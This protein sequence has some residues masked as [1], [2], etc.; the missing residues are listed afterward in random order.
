MI[1]QF[2]ANGLCSGALY[3]IVALGFGLIY[4]STGIFH[5]AH[6]AVY[7]AG[8][9][10]LYLFLIILKFN[11]YISLLFSLLGASILGNLIETLVYNPMRKRKVSPSGFM[12]GSFGVYLFVVNLIALL[13]G[14]ETKVLNPGIEK[15]FSFGS[16]ILTRIQIISF[17]TFIVVSLLFLLFKRTKTGNLIIAFSNNPKLIETIGYNP[18][19]IR[20]IIFTIGSILAAISSSLSALDVGIDPN[21]GMSA[22]F[23][24]AVAVIIGGVNVFE[25]AILGGILIGILQ[26]LVVWQTSAK[27]MDAFTFLILI[28]FLLFRPKGILSKK[29]RIEESV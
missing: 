6:G 19:K 17:I 22:L 27:W 14:N 15:T 24:S 3:S 23:V 21:I 18:Y 28:I 7:V 13:F 1:L 5:F 12:I 26:S 2:L 4:I 25:G 16:V 10:I 8:A 9:Y 20:I 11:I 29:L